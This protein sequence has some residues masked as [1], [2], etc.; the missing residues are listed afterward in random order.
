MLSPFPVWILKTT[1][2]KIKCHTFN[3]KRNNMVTITTYQIIG[4]TVHLAI[5]PATHKAIKTNIV[6]E[7]P[8]DRLDKQEP[9]VN[10][11][12]TFTFTYETK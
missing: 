3:L 12:P 9:R 8:F 11:L 4:K 2:R 6:L 10:P 1:Y 5:T 7:L